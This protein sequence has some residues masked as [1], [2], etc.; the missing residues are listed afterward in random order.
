[1]GEGNHARL[2]VVM[3]VVGTSIGSSGF[4]ETMDAAK[5]HDDSFIDRHAM[6]RAF[7]AFEA[8]GR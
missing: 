4:R 1:M 5:H 8:F 7:L 2:L 3:N 6:V